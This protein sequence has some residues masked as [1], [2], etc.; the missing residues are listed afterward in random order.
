MKGTSCWITLI[1]YTYKLSNRDCFHNRLENRIAEYETNKTESSSSSS[2]SNE[3]RVERSSDDENYDKFKDLNTSASS[4]NSLNRSKDENE[5]EMST[6]MDHLKNMI[7]ACN[8]EQGDRT[9][10][11]Y[12][13]K[14]TFPLTYYW[15][16]SCNI[17]SFLRN[18]N[19]PQNHKAKK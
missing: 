16:Y 7:T 5:V 17:F 13:R 11:Q 6:N 2:S 18:S 3:T 1:L 4:S 12:Y 15:Y 14:N 9:C 10:L 8:L 19:Q